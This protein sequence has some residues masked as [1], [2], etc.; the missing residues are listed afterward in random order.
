MP[1]YA[2]SIQTS[3]FRSLLAILAIA[4]AMLGP[5]TAAAQVLYGSLVG[6]VNDANGAAV[7]SA[8]VTATNQLTGASVPAKPD[9]AGTYQFVNLQ[10]GTYTLRVTM[11]GF[12][13]FE[14]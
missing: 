2:K 6:N 1:S 10:P 5:R 11:S 13:T 8:S 7:P 9:A 3:P 14:R 4:A 12:K